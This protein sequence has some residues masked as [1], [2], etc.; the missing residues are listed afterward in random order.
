MDMAKVALWLVVLW[1]MLGLGL[2]DGAASV[3]LP[4][5][6][7][8]LSDAV[9]TLPPAPTLT[10]VAQMVSY[11]AWVPVAMGGGPDSIIPAE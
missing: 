7:P 10:A 8:T 1:V 4:P 2:R 11:R 3:G 6:T 5:A 9:G